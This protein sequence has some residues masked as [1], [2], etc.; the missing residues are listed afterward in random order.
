[1]PIGVACAGDQSWTGGAEV[2]VGAR[3]YLLH[4]GFT[5]EHISP[6][7]STLLRQ[8]RALRLIPAGRAGQENAW[9][10]QAEI[11][12]NNPAARR[13]LTALV[14]ERDLLARLGPAR[15]LPRAAGM[16]ADGRVA[17]L[18]LGWPAARSG[19]PCDTLQTG[20]DTH[21]AQMDSWHMF[22]LLSGLAGLYD[23]LAGLHEAGAAHRNLTPSGIIV[24]DDGR[25][26]LRDLG[27]A[28]HAYQPGESSG[29]YLAP[30]Q[31]WSARGRPG[32]SADVYQLAAIAYHLLAGHPPH[33]RFP[34]PLSGLAADLPTRLGAGLDAALGADPAAR[35]GARSLSRA[36]RLACDDLS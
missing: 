16:T 32:P 10:R 30:E 15:G 18:V 3:V 4:T 8:A 12:H 23:T 35:P 31:R 21:A 20:L 34:L 6:D 28:A 2:T 13:A 26:V 36:L 7:G 11:R 27:L 33:P 9:L 5:T 17:T 19:G 24:L 1:V 14:A 29:D 25:L 22:R